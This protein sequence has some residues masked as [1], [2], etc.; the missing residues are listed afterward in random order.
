MKKILSVIQR[1]YKYFPIVFFLF[2]I[3]AINSYGQYLKFSEVNTN[4]RKIFLESYNEALQFLDDNTWISDS[5]QSKGIDP[6]FALSIIFPELI[7]YSAIQDKMEMGGLLTLY[8]QYGDKYAD[9]SVGRFQM[10]P[11]FVEHLEDD[12]N[13]THFIDSNLFNRTN[14]SQSRIERVS[15]LNDLKWQVDYL[16]LFIKEMDIRY[17][18]I[19]WGLENDRLKFY[20]TAYN[21]GYLLGEGKIREKMNAKMFYTGLTKGDNCYCYAAIAEDFYTA[22]KCR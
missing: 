17:G 20:A 9:F 6:N 7:R 3:L 5:L 14:T 18:Y 21:S 13:E 8:V 16:V 19:K 10:K 12:A 15:R 4:Y 1:N 11:S 2:N 22:L